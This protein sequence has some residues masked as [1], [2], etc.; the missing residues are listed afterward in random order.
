MNTVLSFIYLVAALSIFYPFPSHAQWTVNTNIKN[1][2]G[3]QTMVAYTSNEAGYS[4]EIYKDSSS[5]IRSRFSLN[6]QLIKFKE[7]TCPTYQIDMGTPGNVS[8]NG[9]PC[10]SSGRW[11]EYILGQIEGNEVSSSILLSIMNGITITFRF[12]LDNGDFRETSISLSGS[13]RSMTTVIGEE[14]TVRAR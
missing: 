4:L 12:Q 2:A 14:I 11:A 3:A 7:R 6:N 8:V 9:A 1:E 13:K 10:L 5:T